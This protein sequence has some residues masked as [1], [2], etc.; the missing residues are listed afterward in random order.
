MADETP[1]VGPARFQHTWK[2]HEAAWLKAQA[3][4]DRA[5]VRAAARAE[6]E[7]EA[8][9][10][11]IRAET[12]RKRRAAWKAEREA[13]KADA[14]APHVVEVA[15]LDGEAPMADRDGGACPVVCLGR[16]DRTY[17]FLSPAGE[18]LEF[19]FGEMTRA[20]VS[21]LFDG[22]TAYLRDNFPT[23]GRD[24]HTVTGFSDGWAGRWLMRQCANAGLF[25]A[26]RVVRGRGV[27]PG[28]KGGYVVH[29]GDRVWLDGEWHQ[30][31]RGRLGG[32]YYPVEDRLPPP[33]DAPATAEEA[34]ALL[35]FLLTW[36]LRHGRRDAL[37]LLGAFA[38]GVLA[39]LLDW[40]P[41]I[42]LV[43]ASN[44]GKSSLIAVLRELLG[45]EGAMIDV[46]QPT[47]AAV[48]QHL[49]AAAMPVLIDEIEADEI[50]T[51]SRQVAQLVRV[52][53]RR[54]Q[55]PVRRGSAGGTGMTWYIR[56][57]FVF[58]STLP[59]PLDEQDENR[60]TKVELLKIG[61]ASEDG[62]AFDHAEAKAKL[63]EGE[64][65]F[66]A[67]SAGLRAR[68]LANWQRDFAT[69]QARYEAALAQAGHTSRQ[70]DQLGT[71]LACADLLLRD[72]PATPEEAART[73]TLFP[74]IGTAGAEPDMDDRHQCLT[75][76]LS[77]EGLAVNE[78]GVHERWTIG[79]MIAKARK[80]PAEE[81]RLR[82]FGLAIREHPATGA[83]ML[84][85]AH[86][87]RGLERVYAQTR[88]Q[89]R[90]WTT[91]L[92]RLD[93]ADTVGGA[94]GVI[95]FAGA[96]RR[97]TWLPLSLIGDDDDRGP[98]PAGN[99]EAAMAELE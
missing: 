56:A 54:D 65:R 47:E 30:A 89:R 20:G 11:R 59:P 57:C 32:F 94:G 85:V 38:A 29:T 39:G 60:I 63:R 81:Q 10:E 9:T 70:L 83:D 31:G 72:R 97:G 1:K 80:A 50:S 15:D 82:A 17:F 51:R 74:T 48:R 45:G 13:D 96:K 36:N 52:A 90:V 92:G 75:W 84:V 93:G 86:D 40:R 6:A 28:P 77:S 42:W 2:I 22:K 58:S 91:S 46:S 55:A 44:T 69:G 73:V 98:L 43:G 7:E 23:F 33:A 3:E 4:K 99:S 87:H 21:C 35:R 41:H 12:A 26:H 64:A 27:W 16:R 68:I 25:H 61:E 14:D 66:K 19:R 34:E 24:G 95:S 8:E 49:G 18:L 67:T 5:A 71:L 62:E 76:L 53:S 78:N 88:W 79:Q 37:V